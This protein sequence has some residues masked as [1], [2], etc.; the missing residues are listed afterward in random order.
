M[1]LVE[2]WSWSFMLCEVVFICF[3]V[4]YLPSETTKLTDLARLVSEIFWTYL[5]SKIVKKLRQNLN[6]I[7]F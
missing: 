4:L 2:K 7:D 6:R 3:F 5:I 1:T